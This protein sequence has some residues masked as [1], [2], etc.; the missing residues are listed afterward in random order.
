MH[1]ARLATNTDGLPWRRSDDD[2]TISTQKTPP[3]L[4]ITRYYWPEL[5]GSAPFS[6]DIAEWLARHGRQ[7]EVLS[8]LRASDRLIVNPADS[9]ADGDTVTLPAESAAKGG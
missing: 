7:V 9:L 4:F 6:S 1:R 3:I 5:I 2:M 8:G